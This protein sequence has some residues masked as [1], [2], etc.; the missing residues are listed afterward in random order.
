MDNEY[1]ER[2]NFLESV[3]VVKFNENM[4]R[5]NNDKITMESRQREWN[6]RKLRLGLWNE[7]NQTDSSSWKKII[8]E[9]YKF[10]RTSL[11]SGDRENCG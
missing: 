10:G 6:L 1:S 2:S 7:S 5:Q 8:L 11:D 3:A 4:A 9:Y